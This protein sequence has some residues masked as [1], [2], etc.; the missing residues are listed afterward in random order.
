M[1]V[2]WTVRRHSVSVTDGMHGLYDV[3]WGHERM[4]RF[5]R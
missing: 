2:R 1:I 5:G 4:C 3:N